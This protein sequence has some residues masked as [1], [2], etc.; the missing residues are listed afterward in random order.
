M[1]EPLANCCSAYGLVPSSLVYLQSFVDVGLQAA[2]P[3]IL[4]KACTVKPDFRG[5]RTIFTLAP[6]PSSTAFPDAKLA[7]VALIGAPATVVVPVP[8]ALRF[9][10][11]AVVLPGVAPAP[12]VLVMLASDGVKL[13]VAVTVIPGENWEESDAPKD[14]FVPKDRFD[15]EPVCN[16]ILIVCP[17]GAG[18]TSG[19]F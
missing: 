5:S 1:D 8:C 19:N 7:S 3:T 16:D 18:V 15:F 12:I 9:E 13:E 11:V 2:E 17:L 14:V 4:G 6:T 10:I